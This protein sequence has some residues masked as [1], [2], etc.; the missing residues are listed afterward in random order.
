MTS[1]V[2]QGRAMESGGILASACADCSTL[3][4]SRNS[5]ISHV[6]IPLQSVSQRSL[7]ANQTVRTFATSNFQWSPVRQDSLKSNQ[8]RSK[9]CEELTQRVL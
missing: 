6:Q 5:D 9:E 4:P 8:T 3:T 7:D 2:P 1:N